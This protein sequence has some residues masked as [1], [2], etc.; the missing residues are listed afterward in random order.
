MKKYYPDTY[1]IGIIRAFATMCDTAVAVYHLDII[2]LFKHL[3]QTDIFEEF[4]DLMGVYS[5]ADTYIYHCFEEEFKTPVKEKNM[6]MSLCICMILMWHIG[7]DI[8]CFLGTCRMILVVL[9]C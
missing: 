4:M 8:F 6:M 9:N 5:Q 7:W 1:E 2:D 3:L